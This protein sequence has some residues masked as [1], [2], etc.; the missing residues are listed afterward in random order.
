MTTL[1][2]PTNPHRNR[3]YDSVLLLLI[4]LTVSDAQ[5]WRPN[6]T[7]GT[8]SCYVP[9]RTPGSIDR[10]L[11]AVLVR[12]PPLLTVT[13]LFPTRAAV[14]VWFRVSEIVILELR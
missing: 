9:E 8:S 7:F 6:E 5:N 1:S 13:P 12:T 4:S 2:S 11:K 10:Y 3:R 14:V